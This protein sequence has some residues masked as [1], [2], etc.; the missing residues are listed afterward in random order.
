MEKPGNIIVQESS[1]ACKKKYSCDKCGYATSRKSQYDRHR[2]TEKHQ[3]KWME[4]IPDPIS[5]K[6]ECMICNKIFKTNS[7]DQKFFFYTFYP[8]AGH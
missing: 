3:R 2:D 4:T 7:T 6:Y 5:S 1:W 8:T